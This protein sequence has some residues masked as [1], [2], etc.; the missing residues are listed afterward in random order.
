[1]TEY[2]FDPLRKKRVVLTPEERV[3]QSFIMWLNAEKHY[4]L[5]LMASECSIIYNGLNYRCD[6]VVFDKNIN[7]L[8][9]VECKSPN[10]KINSE[11]LKQIMKYNLVLKVKYL[12]ITN[13]VITFA[14]K[15]NEIEEKYDFISDI[16]CYEIA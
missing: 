4:S 13:G 5:Q 7:P 10:I 14:C 3:R 8:I 11:T 12:I 9:I 6:I 1:M 15:Y 2:I 16:P